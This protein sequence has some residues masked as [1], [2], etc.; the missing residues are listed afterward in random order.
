[1]TMPFWR[2]SCGC[3]VL[4]LPEAMARLDDPP[5]TFTAAVISDCR[6]EDSRLAFSVKQMKRKKLLP[7]QARPLTPTEARDLCMRLGAALMMGH[8]FADLCRD[9]AWGR[10]V[11]VSAPHIPEKPEG[12]T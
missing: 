7:P 5:N 12:T 4:V 9:L 8:T 3:V 10:G 11:D 1:M 6:G 2:L